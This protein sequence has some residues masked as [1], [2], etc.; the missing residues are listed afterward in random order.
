MLCDLMD[1]SYRRQAANKDRLE[2]LLET[3]L[4]GWPQLFACSRQQTNLFGVCDLQ[5]I[6]LM[7]NM[8]MI[9][10]FPLH[11]IRHKVG[12]NYERWLAELIGSSRSEVSIEMKTKAIILLPTVLG[13]GGTAGTESY[14]ESFETALDTLQTLHFP[15]RSTEFLPNSPKRIGFLNCLERLLE[16]MIVSRSPLL[17]KVI[18][19]MTAPDGEGHIAE[20]KIRNAIERF[21]ADQP[22]EMQCDR[23]QELWDLFANHAY[24]PT[25][26]ETILRR[27]LC[28]ALWHCRYDT[29]VEFYKRIIRSISSFTTEDISGRSGWDLEHALVDLAASFRLVEHYAALLPKKILTGDNCP[30][31]KQLYSTPK[32]EGVPVRGQR[33]IGDFSKRAHSVRRAVLLSNDRSAVELF[34]KYQCAA[35][36][37]L[38]ALI[39][40]TNED[41][42]M[43]SVLLFRETREKGEFLWRH[44]VDCSNDELYLEGSQEQDETTRTVAKRVAIRQE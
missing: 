44:L 23:L 14:W 17:L 3:L 11:D 13:P 34:R 12:P 27:Y 36:R 32:D 31:A 9:C 4:N 29:I 33:L 37:A 24:A 6:E 2:N 20:A 43:Y 26:R 5:M 22:F 8:V 38:V 25:V 21:F 19:Q 30:V 41:A 39:S 42:R 40:N 1:Y 15:L 7:T 35:Y 10:P 28:T 16:A 18:I